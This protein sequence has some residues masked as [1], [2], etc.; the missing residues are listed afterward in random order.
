MSVTDRQAAEFALKWTW[1]HFKIER[2]PATSPLRD[3]LY[4]IK[5]LIERIEAAK[6]EEKENPASYHED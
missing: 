1:Q 6:P 2:L 3:V 5:T 4:R